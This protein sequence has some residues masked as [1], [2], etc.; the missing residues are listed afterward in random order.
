MYWKS[1]VFSF[2]FF[3][4]YIY[5][6]DVLCDPQFNFCFLWAGADHVALV[7]GRAVCDKAFL[8][9][10]EL[11]GLCAGVGEACLVLGV[12]A[13]DKDV[14][15]LRGVAVNKKHSVVR[16]FD[17]DDGDPVALVEQLCLVRLTVEAQL[18]CLQCCVFD[19]VYCHVLTF[20]CN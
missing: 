15:Q 9:D 20:F 12:P 6:K 10:M 19:D 17:V 14:A 2:F 13:C 16:G 5:L 1:S 4:L 3:F 11:G 18:H 7:A 8:E